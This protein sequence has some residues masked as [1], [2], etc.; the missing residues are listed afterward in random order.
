MG[1]NKFQTAYYVVLVM[2]V[3]TML[4]TGAVAMMT[5]CWMSAINT[6]WLPLLVNGF[7]VYALKDWRSCSTA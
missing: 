1:G 6:F 7:L 4:S 5:G 3:L 2:L